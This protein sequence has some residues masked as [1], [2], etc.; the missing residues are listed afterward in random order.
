ML[1]ISE[2]EKLVCNFS[3]WNYLNVSSQYFSVFLFLST[4]GALQKLI[5]M[6]TE[7]TR[8]ARDLHQE[9]KGFCQSCSTE[10]VDAEV[11]P[12]S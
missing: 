3:R 6:V 7:L 2:Q 9:F 8:E 10:P 5:I 1:F 4:D 11:L 12:H